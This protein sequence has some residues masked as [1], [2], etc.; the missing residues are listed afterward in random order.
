MEERQRLNMIHHTPHSGRDEPSL[1][2][3]ERYAE[4]R[5]ILKLKEK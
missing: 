3:T 2:R 1:L 5:S 4:T